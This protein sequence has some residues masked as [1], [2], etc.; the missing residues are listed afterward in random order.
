MR[1][2][3][4][5]YSS[6]G[7][8]D[9]L[10][11]HKT[12]YDF[13]VKDINGKEVSMSKYKGQVV[14]VVNVAS[15]CGYTNNHYTELKQLQEKYYDQGLRIAAFPCNQFGSQEP[16][17]EA[18]IKRFVKETFRYEPDMY[19]KIDVNGDNA[20]PFWQFLKSE[21][22]GTLIDAIKWNF[23]KFLINRKGYVVKRFA[24]TTSPLGMTADIERLLHETP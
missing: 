3:N 20:D 21:Q 10:S 22:G 13:T 2:I 5:A 12:I 9:P 7:D 24:P 15:Y 8:D 4:D 19:S 23:T 18:D 17:P 16:S 1:S 6:D 14:I 11:A